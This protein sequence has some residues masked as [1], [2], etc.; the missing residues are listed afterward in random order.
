MLEKKVILPLDPHGLSKIIKALNNVFK[1]AILLF[2]LFLRSLHICMS[3]IIIYK[4][5]FI[6]RTNV[7]WKRKHQEWY[8][9]W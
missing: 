5:Y 8:Y 1:R 9:F 2:L 7:A 4:W 6:Q 3:F